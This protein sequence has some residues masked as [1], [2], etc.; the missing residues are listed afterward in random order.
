MVFPDGRGVADMLVLVL[1]LE[2]VLLVQLF[3]LGN[4]LFV[5]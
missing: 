1:L 3:R 4:I 5:V 2:L